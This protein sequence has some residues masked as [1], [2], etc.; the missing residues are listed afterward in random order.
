MYQKS[1][2]HEHVYDKKLWKIFKNQADL[3]FLKLEISGETPASCEVWIK[4]KQEL[5]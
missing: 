1:I 5:P 4:F 3:S 2:Y